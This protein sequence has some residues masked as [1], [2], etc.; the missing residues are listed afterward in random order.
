MTIYCIVYVDEPT[1]LLETVATPTADMPV[2][3]VN[4]EINKRIIYLT[5]ANLPEE[6]CKDWAWFS[7]NYWFNK[8]SLTFVKVG[9][10]PN[11]FASYDFSTNSWTW[12]KAEILK[13]I[14][15]ERNGRLFGTDWTQVADNT[16]TDAQKA[17]ALAYRKALRD[18]M[19][20]VDNPATVEEAPWPE[21]PCFLQ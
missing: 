11:D 3:G 7:Q 17:E 19:P 14:R 4:D 8:T 18:M 9:N 5:E 21:I 16:L 1:G 6:K 2:E 10:K 12:D 15:R 20:N 13:M